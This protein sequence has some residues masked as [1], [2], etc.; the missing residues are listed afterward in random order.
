MYL[1]ELSRLQQ[2]TN[3]KCGEFQLKTEN[4]DDGIK[5]GEIGKLGQN[6]RI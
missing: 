6:V 1:I 4:V 2:K 5:L 3:S